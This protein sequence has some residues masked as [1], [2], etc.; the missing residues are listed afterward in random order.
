MDWEEEER[1]RDKDIVSAS[2]CMGINCFRNALWHLCNGGLLC[3]IYCVLLG[4]VYDKD[5]QQVNLLECKVW[6]V[7]IFKEICDCFV[8]LYRYKVSVYKMN[9]SVTGRYTRGDDRGAVHCVNLVETCSNTLLCYLDFLFFFIFFSVRLLSVLRDHSVFA[10]P[11]QRPCYL[12][13]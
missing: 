8:R 7:R 10:S 13:K 11:P 2:D 5:T 1:V 3:P 6:Y 12:D 9:H 4:W